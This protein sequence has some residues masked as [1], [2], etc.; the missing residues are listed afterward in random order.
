MTT[1]K[2]QIEASLDF[3]SSCVSATPLRDEVG[4]FAS[5]RIESGFADG[6]LEGL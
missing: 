5:E 2:E 6:L 4:L 3:L 1:E